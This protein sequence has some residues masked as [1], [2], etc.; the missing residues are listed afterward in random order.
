M[1]MLGAVWVF[2]FQ[3][4]SLH[5]SPGRRGAESFFTIYFIIRFNKID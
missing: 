4:T 1:G 3:Q 5:R 2:R